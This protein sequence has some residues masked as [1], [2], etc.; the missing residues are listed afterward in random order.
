MHTVLQKMYAEG[1]SRGLPHQLFPVFGWEEGLW[2]PLTGVVDSI[3]VNGSYLQLLLTSLKAEVTYSTP[4][5]IEHLARSKIASC[6]LH[7]Y[8]PIIFFKWV[9]RECNHIRPYFFISEE[10]H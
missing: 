3:L 1:I 4:P 10:K 5:R 6:N 7:Y 2:S 8:H 9:A